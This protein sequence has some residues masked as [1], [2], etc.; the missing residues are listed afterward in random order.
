MSDPAPAPDL[1]GAPQWFLDAIN[2]PQVSRKAQ[3]VDGFDIHYV[4][5]N[6]SEKEK[7][8]LLFVHGYRASTHAWDFVAPLFT[9]HYR[10]YAMDLGG[11]GESDYRPEYDISTFSRDIDAV[12]SAI[13]DGPIYLVG[14]SFGGVALLR[15]INDCPDKVE[16]MVL[17]DSYLYLPGDETPS[18]TKKGRP[19][20]YPDYESIIARYVL[21]P[22]QPTEPWV[23]NFMASH[24]VRPV[25]GGWKWKF[26]TNLPAGRP[27]PE[28]TENLET[29]SERCDFICGEHSE[30]VPA[31]KVD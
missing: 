24:A 23:Y 28:C 10:V 4:S 7:P 17:I 20:P 25:E 5:W 21:L 15:F 2:K 13:S 31:D 18:S 27:Y 29:Y 3:T 6:E 14:H 11:M 22:P 19:T 30:V 12:V 8:V 16:H 9:N 26:D 1:Q